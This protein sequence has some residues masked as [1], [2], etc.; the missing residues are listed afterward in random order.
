MY[1][2]VLPRVTTFLTII[3]NSAFV[4][5]RIMEIEEGVISNLKYMYFNTLKISL[6]DLLVQYKIKLHNSI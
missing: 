5:W 1:F 2:N 3:L 6:S 4:I